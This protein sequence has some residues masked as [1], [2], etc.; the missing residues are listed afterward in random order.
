MLRLS[1]RLFYSREPRFLVII[2]KAY[3][4]SL[5]EGGCILWSHGIRNLINSVEKVQKR[6]YRFIPSIR[7]LM[8][9]LS[10]AEFGLVKFGS[11]KLRY[12]LIFLKG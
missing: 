7:Q 2:Y 12:R 10:V 8:L 9:S 1:R 5:L 6:F 11:F 4:L 3:V